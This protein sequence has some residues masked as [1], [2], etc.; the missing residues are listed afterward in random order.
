[1]FLEE[2]PLG[3]V[4]Q[5]SCAENTQQVYWRTHMQKYGLNKVGFA[6]LL[7]THLR[8]DLVQ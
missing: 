4:L 2:A 1:M 3:G 7:K 6:T 8:I 5:K